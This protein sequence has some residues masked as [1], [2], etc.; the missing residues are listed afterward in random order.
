[1]FTRSCSYVRSALLP[2]QS[3]RCG[4]RKIRKM[5]TRKRIG[6]CVA[7][8]MRF[9]RF[10][11]L[12][13]RPTGSTNGLRLAAQRPASN[14]V[15]AIVRLPV[16]NERMDCRGGSMKRDLNA[17]QQGLSTRNLLVSAPLIL[18]MVSVTSGEKPLPTTSA[19]SRVPAKSLQ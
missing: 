8:V 6:C 15:D 9:M 17:F 5:L 18:S 4:R 14:R 11:V 3:P 1:M 7:T 13:Q 19:S 16:T 2:F 12:W 10:L